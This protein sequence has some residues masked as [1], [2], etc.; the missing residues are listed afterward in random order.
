MQN[1]FRKLLGRSAHRQKRNFRGAGE[2]DA[3]ADGADAAADPELGVVFLKVTVDV[4]SPVADFCGCVTD[5][6]DAALPAM[7]VAG[8]LERDGALGVKLVKDIGLVDEGDDGVA[9]S[10]AFPSAGGIDVAAPDGVERGDEDALAFDVEG[11][12]IILEVVDSC[13]FDVF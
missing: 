11:G 13:A 1:Y 7:G 3:E 2:A 12:A 10:V 5:E 9:F 6:G 4:V 8:E